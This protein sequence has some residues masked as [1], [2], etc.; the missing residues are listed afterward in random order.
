VALLELRI[1]I[2][3][4]QHATLVTQTRRQNYSRQAR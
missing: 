4:V 2:G 3:V 1:G